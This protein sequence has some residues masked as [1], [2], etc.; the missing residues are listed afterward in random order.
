MYRRE[1][2][3]ESGTKGLALLYALA[4]IAHTPQ[5][6]KAQHTTS[7]AQSGGGSTLLMNWPR[8]WGQ[9]SSTTASSKTRGR[10]SGP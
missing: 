8:I 6:Q 1:G 4:P 5:A 9:Y 3:T 10:W 2:F 7:P